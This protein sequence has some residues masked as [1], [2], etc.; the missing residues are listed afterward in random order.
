VVVDDKY[1]LKIPSINTTFSVYHV[2]IFFYIRILNTVFF[3]ENG[4]VVFKRAFSE[5]YFQASLL[6]WET[7]IFK[8]FIAEV[9]TS[10]FSEHRGALQKP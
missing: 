6:S 2:K 8:V 9:R 1:E 5:V 3:L 4:K 7:F 10:K